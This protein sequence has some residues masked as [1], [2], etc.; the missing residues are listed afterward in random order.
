MH[1]T[2]AF[3]ALVVILFAACSA[4][5]PTP[6]AKPPAASPAPTEV[7]YPAPPGVTVVAEGLLQ[8]RGMT[9]GPDG[10]LYIAE[11]G[12]APPPDKNAV[13]TG[14]I[15]KIAPDGTRSV[16]LDQIATTGTE[17]NG[18]LGASALAVIS[19]TLYLSAAGPDGGRGD[20]KSGVYRI[21]K[22]GTTQLLA[23]LGQF[24]DDH[25]PANID[26]DYDRANPYGMVALNGKLYISDGNIQVINEV[27]PLAPQGSNVRRVADMSRGHPV[28]TGIVAGSDGNLYV[29]EFTHGP[30]TEAFSEGV[31]QVYRVTLDGQVTPIASGLTMAMG[32]AQAPDGTFYATE[33]VSGLDKV[34]NFTGPGRLVKLKAGD[35]Q[36][37]EVV[38]NLAYPS[39]VVWGPDGF[40]YFGNYGVTIPWNGPQRG[41][42]YKI[43]P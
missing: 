5:P 4:P 26:I 38:S 19:D 15:T 39:G 25:K 1:R 16:V 2:L 17:F 24:N 36:V 18:A 3:L 37:M 31:A 34:G 27:D 33:F 32:L 43:K 42:V 13:N 12:I 23:D 40:V 28:L 7:G 10:S 29:T 41:A 22:D 9:F 20:A 6:T 35:S 8:P 30:Y 14:R 11:A 21:N